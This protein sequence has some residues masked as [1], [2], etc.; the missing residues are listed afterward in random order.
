ML[1]VAPFLRNAVW[2]LCHF[3]YPNLSREGAWFSATALKIRTRLWPR[4]YAAR[5][6]LSPTFRYSERAEEMPVRAREIFNQP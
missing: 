3:L 4:R 1:M 6:V 5:H 2:F